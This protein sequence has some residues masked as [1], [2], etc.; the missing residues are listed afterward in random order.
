MRRAVLVRKSVVQV[1]VLFLLLTVAAVALARM[2]DNAW[3]IS[4]AATHNRV[5]T[6][7][8]VTMGTYHTLRAYGVGNARPGDYAASDPAALLRPE[9]PP[10]T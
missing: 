8:D 10:Y 2:Q 7:L 1:A 3:A 4:D 9:D 6:T 5:W